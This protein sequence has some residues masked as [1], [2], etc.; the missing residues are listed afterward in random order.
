MKA[1]KRSLFCLF[2]LFLFFCT[3]CTVFAD[4]GPKDQL[5]VYLTNPPQETYYLDLLWQPDTDNLSPNLNAE[6]LA[7]LD[8]ALLA[9]LESEAPQGWVPAMAVGTPVPMWGD[10]VGHPQGAQRVH[11]F[12]YVGLPEVCRILLVTESGQTLLTEPIER[13]VLQSSV[14]LD[15]ASG[16]LHQSS[17]AVALG[18]SFLAT[19]LPTLLIEGLLLLAFGFSL[20]QNWKVFLLANLVTQIGLSLTVHLTMLSSG[21][22]T[23]HLIQF[24]VELAILI[25]ETLFY[26]RF[27]T[28]K[29][30]GRRTGYGICANLVSWAAGFL[31]MGMLF[32]LMVSLC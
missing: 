19:L 22:I 10:L 24:P 32:E 8:P 15:C 3:L 9:R 27:L 31:S 6:E 2:S 20:R 29:S 18:V 5:K 12:G 23:A 16:R 4:I 28:G 7:A 26:R 13:R 17:P 21:S 14:T 25:A 1:K 11:V 30:V